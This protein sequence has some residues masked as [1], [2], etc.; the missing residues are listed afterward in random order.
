VESD[1]FLEMPVSTQA[2]YFHLG[3]N[4]DDDGFVN[5]KMIMRMIGVEEDDLKVL[6]AKRFVLAFENGVVVI[7]HWLIHNTIR[8]DRYH[9]TQYLDQKDMLQIKDNKAYTE[10]WQP[11]GNQMAP[12]VKTRQVKLIQDKKIPFD[13]FWEIYPKKTGKKKAEELWKN[14]KI[15]DQQKAIEDIPKRKSDDKWK[16]GFIKDPERYIKYEQWN[17]EIIVKNGKPNDFL[18]TQTGKYDGIKTTTI[19][20]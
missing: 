13:S 9:P 12:E 8:L 7:K 6:L 14:L 19:K 15:E 4:A 18:K 11:N 17:D 3:M 16:G 2:L 10:L 5:P 1:A 20:Q